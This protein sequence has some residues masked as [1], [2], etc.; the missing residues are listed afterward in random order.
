MPIKR[1]KAKTRVEGIRFTQGQLDAI[2]RLVATERYGSTRADVVRFFV[3][4]GIAELDELAKAAALTA[5]EAKMPSGPG[6]QPES[7]NGELP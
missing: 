6:P 5:N 1:S 4:R 3:M 7:S 2:D